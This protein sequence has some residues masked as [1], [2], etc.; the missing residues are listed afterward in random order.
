MMLRQAI[1]LAMYL[2]A[3]ANSNIYPTILRRYQAPKYRGSSLYFGRDL[4]YK[5]RA[6]FQ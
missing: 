5:L 6:M 3:A 2:T 1:P 4:P